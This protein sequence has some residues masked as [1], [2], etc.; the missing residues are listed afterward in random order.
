MRVFKAVRNAALAVAGLL[1]IIASEGAVAQPADTPL[2]VGVSA[3]PYGDILREAAKVAAKGEL[4][5][6]IIEFTDWNQP[7]A[8][9]QA[10]DIDLNNFQH[11][12]YLAN[13]IKARNYQIV[14]LDES[15]LVPAGIYSKT[16]AKAA[17]IPDGA[18]IAI[19]N[20]PTNA[21]RAL[22]LFQKAGLITLKA[23]AG[24][25]ASVLDVAS[26]PR[27]LQIVEI[28]AAQLP[29]SL[30]DVA[31]AFVSSNYA[32]LA[33]LDL[34]KALVAETA[35]A[36]MKPYFTLVFA[37]RADRKD[38]PRIKAFIAAY[39]SQQ[40]KDFILAKFNGTI[41]PTC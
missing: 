14:A 41:L 32:Y 24:L 30:D 39:R 22:Y 40:V 17:D 28:D 2:K 26:N 4:K 1:T 27:K 37:A 15:I 20:D 34:R 6:E 35:D 21:A 33:G 9:L 29:R 25:D 3:G 31:A 8:A 5:A 18:K 19:P 23:G 7:N 38:D 16:Y 36:E 10:G 13:Q 11:R 12:F